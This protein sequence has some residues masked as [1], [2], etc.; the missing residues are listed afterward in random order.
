MLIVGNSS[1]LSGFAGT[2][3]GACCT[4][5]VSIFKPATHHLLGGRKRMFHYVA[6]LGDQSS[7]VLS[8]D[9]PSCC[10]AMARGRVPTAALSRRPRHDASR[11]APEAP[12]PAGMRTLARALKCPDLPA[13]N[14]GYQTDVLQALAKDA[15]R[16]E[17]AKSS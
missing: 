11:G 2:L 9:A 3:L 13:D 14:S 5:E 4:N 17:F 16:A 8:P 7:A 1:I 10:A 6:A 12:Q 15:H